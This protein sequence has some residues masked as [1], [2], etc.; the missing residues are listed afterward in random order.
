MPTRT[1]RGTIDSNWGTA[2]NWAEGAVPTSAD[3]VVFDA[4][5]PACTVNST[6]RVCLSID[7]SAYTNTITMSNN[8]TVGAA[9]GT[10]FIT[11]GASM[12]IAE[13]GQLEF[14]GQGNAT[15]TTNGRTWPNQ[16]NFLNAN[17]S[18]AT[19]TYTLND[20][21]TFGGLLSIS[22]GATAGRTITFTSS[23]A[24][25]ITCNAGITSAT[26]ANPRSSTFTMTFK[27]TSGTISLSAGIA[28]GITIDLDGSANT[29]T[30]TGD[31]WIG[32]N[33]TLTSPSASTLKFTSGTIDALSSILYGG[34][35]RF[36]NLNGDVIFGSAFL[37]SSVSSTHNINI[38]SGNSL[39]IAGTYSLNPSFSL[40]GNNTTFTG[41]G[42]L[43]CYNLTYNP[44]SGTG[45][46][47]GA[48][49][50]VFWGSGT[51]SNTSGTSNGVIAVTEV[52]FDSGNS[53]L[54]TLTGSIYIGGAAGSTNFNVVSGTVV[55]TGLVSFT[56]A[57]SSTTG[58]SN[59]TISASNT[60]F[61]FLDFSSISAGGSFTLNTDLLVRGRVS[62][63]SAGY[64]TNA[65][66]FALAGTG[67]INVLGS[68]LIGLSGITSITINSTGPRVK[69]I[70]QGTWSVSSTV[71]GTS[72]A[73]PLEIDTPD[74][75]TIS[76]TVQKTNSLIHTRGKVIAP[77]GSIL[78]CAGTG[79]VNMHRIAFATVTLTG[80]ITMNEFFCGRPGRFCTINTSTGANLTVTF[81]N[82][83]QKISRWIRP[84]NI[85]ITN[86]GQLTIMSRNGN[87]NNTNI[88]IL[89]FEG[90]VPFGTS[91]NNPITYQAS[92][93]FGIADNPADPNF[94]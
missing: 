9:T 54:T 15:L 70:G 13:S 37:G 27:I 23:A 32:F 21:C 93:C 86:R 7:F 89:H 85:T 22:G 71:T 4:S 53:G 39:R 81:T 94:F 3:D 30:F 59:P 45:L 29:I 31:T 87:R 83:F 62:F 38:P 69:L 36:E 51:L 66:T 33:T 16:F 35:A 8:I 34:N 60:S 42:E 76:G 56:R 17:A 1:W 2:G 65:L 28:H 58:I 55:S 72:F 64:Q 5:S 92:N 20:N 74:T 43:W 57:N 46:I 6:N 26:N 88:G 82:G 52:K 80:N 19:I 10:I 91:R 84:Q 78:R 24:R 73:I 63:G 47:S 18:N 79:F 48:V 25:T 41:G 90:G 11:L 49:T 40:S 44:T 12:G 75:I 61:N 50:L 68:L 14:S 67:N 77:T